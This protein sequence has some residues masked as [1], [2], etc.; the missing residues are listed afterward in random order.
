MFKGKQ[1]EILVNPLKP[2]K[3]DCKNS[4]SFLKMFGIVST[5]VGVIGDIVVIWYFLIIS[6][7]I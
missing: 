6:Y 2:N 5:L 3:I 4:I 7:T 1:I